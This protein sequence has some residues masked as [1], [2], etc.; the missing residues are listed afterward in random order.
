M[1]NVPWCS[2][3]DYC[4][5]KSELSKV[6]TQQ[7]STK[8]ELRFCAGSNPAHGASQI[9]YNEYL[10]QWYRLEIR[11]KRLSSVNHTTKAFLHH[12]HHHHHH[13]Q[14]HHDRHYH[15]N[16]LK[17]LKSISARFLKRAWSFWVVVHLKVNV[18]TDGGWTW[19][20]WDWLLTTR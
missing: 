15:Q 19:W 5:T 14:Y 18:E 20:G 1:H 12:H 3:Y 11:L 8:S 4:T 7:N 2:G 9:R 16:T 13:H 6:W 10:W 17:I